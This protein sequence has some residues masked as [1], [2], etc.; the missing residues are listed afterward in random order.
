ME[1]ANCFAREGES[2]GF[3]LS[4]SPKALRWKITWLRG[5]RFSPRPQ[6]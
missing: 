4:K 2:K 6:R 1:R 5:S 3:S